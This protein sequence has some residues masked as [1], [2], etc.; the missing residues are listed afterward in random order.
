MTTSVQVQ[1]RPLYQKI[2][3]IASVILFVGGAL[4]GIMTYK[5]V[6]ITETFM[7]DWFSSFGI[8]ALVMVPTGY[9]MMTVVSKLI[10][11]SM[12]NSRKKHQQVVTGLTMAVIMESV[13]A[14]STTANTIGYADKNTFL[15]AWSQAFITA[16]PFGL[17]MAIVMSV[18]L[19]PKLDQFMA[20]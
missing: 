5:N 6:G 15:L 16:L 13:M 10:Q 17:C 8:A 12:P 3:V 1:K 7:T 20:S 18:F 9:I 2:M 19:K 11:I 14:L 4:T